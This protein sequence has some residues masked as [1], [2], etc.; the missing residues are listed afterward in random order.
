MPHAP[1]LRLSQYYIIEGL[2]SYCSTLILYTIFFWTQKKFNYSDAANLFLAASQGFVTIFA[3][4][5]G[6]QVAD[7]IG[8]DRLLSLCALILTGILLLGWIPSWWIIPFLIVI[9][10]ALFIGPTWPALEAAILHAPASTT[11]P[12]RLG[13]YNITWAAANALAFFTGGIFFKWQPDSLFWI[14]AVLH[15]TQWGLLRMGAQNTPN[16]GIAAMDIPHSGTQISREI[17]KKFMYTAWLGNGLGFLMLV[18]FMALAPFMGERL[19]L[20]TRDTIWLTST[21]LFS[22]ACA[23]FLFWK[24]ETW[25]YHW[26]WMMTALWTAPFTLGIAF[27]THHIGIIVFMLIWFGLATG[28]SYSSSLY[29]SM[30]YGENKGEH[31]G[32]HEAILG[33]GVFIGCLIAGLVAAS[34]EGTTIAEWSIVL[35]TVF[36]NLCGLVLI[37]K[38][39]SLGSKKTTS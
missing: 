31:A 35:L 30:D 12:N 36:L 23:F 22:R 1:K 15:L 2:N 29:Y 25:H 10:Y 7:R 19:G 39:T 8:Y 9:L 37:K 34:R 13:F 28:L 18:G 38:T 17:K 21:P 33:A 6:G 27:F 11:M 5:F 24:W 4:K 3:T 14:A 26:G 32:L 16:P 20:E